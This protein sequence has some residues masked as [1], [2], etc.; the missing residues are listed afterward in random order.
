MVNAGISCI[1]SGGLQTSSTLSSIRG[2]TTLLAVPIQFES[3]LA[4]VS[5][6]RRGRADV[7]LSGDDSYVLNKSWT[8]HKHQRTKTTLCEFRPHKALPTRYDLQK[9]LRR[10]TNVYLKLVSQCIQTTC[11][12]SP[13]DANRPWLL[14][15]LVAAGFGIRSLC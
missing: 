10:L 2:P 15:C 12:H 7:L 3:G 4:S 6:R 13:C 14:S 8:R 9:L 11:M 5:F 1:E